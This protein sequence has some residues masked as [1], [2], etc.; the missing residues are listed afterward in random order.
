[1]S[2]LDRIYFNWL[3]DSYRL[4]RPHASLAWWAPYEK[5]PFDTHGPG[6]LPLPDNTE[7]ILR[8]YVASVKNR[9][10][11]LLPLCPAH[12]G[13]SWGGLLSERVIHDLLDEGVDVPYGKCEL[14]SAEHSEQTANSGGN[15]K[16]LHELLPVSKSPIASLPKYYYLAPVSAL[17]RNQP[18]TYPYQ[19]YSGQHDIFTQRDRRHLYCAFRIVELARKKKWSNM[20]MVM[21]EQLVSQ[22]KPNY[23]TVMCL[24]AKAADWPAQ[25]VKDMLALGYRL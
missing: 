15:R 25:C 17:N 4:G 7:R 19:A 8:V 18:A 21:C 13:L 5:I 23:D 6:Y 11:D 16:S 14:V 9:M 24:D 1:M 22:M 12:G 2:K 10:P 3:H 20:R